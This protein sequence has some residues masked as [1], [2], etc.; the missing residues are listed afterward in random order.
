MC[1]CNTRKQTQGGQM[2]IFKNIES[3]RLWLLSAVAK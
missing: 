2:Q 1:V 3:A